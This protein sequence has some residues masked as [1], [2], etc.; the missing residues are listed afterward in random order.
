MWKREKKDNSHTFS[1]SEK[2][3]EDLV[4]KKNYPQIFKLFLFLP[5]FS[6]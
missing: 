1:L 2:A 3:V 5:N 4:K 6:N